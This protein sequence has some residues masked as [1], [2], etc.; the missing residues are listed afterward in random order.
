MDSD[1]Q[2]VPVVNIAGRLHNLSQVTR[3]EGGAAGV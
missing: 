1:I 3:L 2:A